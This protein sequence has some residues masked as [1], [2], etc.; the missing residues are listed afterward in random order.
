MKFLIINGVNLNM[1]GVREKEIYGSSSYKD[2]VK[3]IK[4]EAKK[5]EV[6]CDFYLSNYEGKI[7][8]KIQKACHRYDGII[9]NPGAYTHYSIA[10]LDALKAVDIP[11]V[12][13]HISD[14]NAREEFR[15]KS[16]TGQAALEIISGKGLQGYIEALDLLIKKGEER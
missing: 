11:Y 7:V 4:A 3:L 14:I 5:R 12:E 13:V 8:T 16:I 1:L 2:L 6:K 15:Q 10:I 9:I